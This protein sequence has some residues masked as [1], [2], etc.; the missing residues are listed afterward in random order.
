MIG[1]A[2]AVAAALL[3]AFGSVA[4]TQDAR[5]NGGR[6]TAVVLS[7]LLTTA[8]SGLLWLFIGLPLPTPSEGL[9]A[10]IAYFCVAG[11]LATVIGRVFFFRAIELTGAVESSLFRRL[12]PIFAVVMAVIFLG[13]RV[14]LSTAVAIVLVFAGVGIVILSVPENPQAA[15]VNTAERKDRMTGRLLGVG[16]AA[17]Y[18]GAYVTRKFGMV[19]L[20]DPLAGTFIGAIAGLVVFCALAPLNEHFRAQI[21][22]VLRRPTRWQVLAAGAISFGQIAQFTALKFT[23]VTAVAIIASIEMFFAAWLAGFVLRSEPRPGPRLLAASVLALIG[24][25]ILALDRGGA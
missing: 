23:S 17:S 22:A 9:W 14:T 16:S 3:Y 20:P 15:K 8:I 21:R 10:G 12:I 24:V 18:G 5:E 6:G 11:L 4:V 1:E 25:T 13:E 2:F 7:I 19:W